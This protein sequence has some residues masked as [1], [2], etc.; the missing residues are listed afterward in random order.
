MT[1]T[2]S[3]CM[4]RPPFPPVGLP[5]SVPLSQLTLCPQFTLYQPSHLPLHAQIPSFPQ[6]NSASPPPQRESQEPKG[7]SVRPKS[8]P[9]TKSTPSSFSIES[10]LS[11]S[12]DRDKSARTS[13]TTP[14]GLN[15]PGHAPRGSLSP[16]TPLSAGPKSFYYNVIYPSAAQGS[17]FPFATAQ[18][19]L[20]HDLQRSPCSLSRLSAPLVLGDVVRQCGKSALSHHTQTNKHKCTSTHPLYVCM[21]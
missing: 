5:Q 9:T 4:S 7:Q 19:C 21:Y 13:A 6:P 11:K 14:Q 15:A 10:I 3:T 2:Y 17:P 8:S 12:D 18:P 1:L 20:D 16:S